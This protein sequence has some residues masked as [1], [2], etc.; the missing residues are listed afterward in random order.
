MEDIVMINYDYFAVIAKFIL[1]GDPE[2]Q[3]DNFTVRKADCDDT[4]KMILDHCSSIKAD[5][6]VRDSGLAV[7]VEDLN[8]DQYRVSYKPMNTRTVDAAVFKDRFCKY[9][10]VL[11]TTILE[12]F[13]QNPDAELYTERRGERIH[14]GVKVG[15][16]KV[17]EGTVK[18]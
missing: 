8:P 2:L 12:F 7:N 15:A 9:D 3:Y 18:V 10:S 17:Y 13:E 11:A 16:D 1:D 4:W 14:Y 5:V 6:L